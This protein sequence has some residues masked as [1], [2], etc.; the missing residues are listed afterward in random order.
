MKI[1]NYKFLII[2]GLAAY[3]LMGCKPAGGN[4]PGSEY[5]PDM[6]HS[7]AFEANVFEHYNLNTWSS[8]EELYQNAQPRKPVAGT[9]PFGEFGALNRG[10]FSPEMAEAMKTIP[11]NGYVPF[12]YPDTEEGRQAA[13]SEITKNPFPITE[14][15]LNNGKAL[16]NIYCGICHG[17]NGDGLGYLARDDGSYPVA[18]A[19]L[20]ADRFIDTT[21]GLYIYSIVHGKNVMGSYAD[22]LST[23][24]RWDVIHHIRKLQADKVGAEYSPESNTFVPHEAIT[25]KEA[26]SMM[27]NAGINRS[28]EESG[29]E[30][31][32]QDMNN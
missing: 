25:A 15:G 11:V 28:M 4:H 12:Y 26:Q 9:I 23:K 32:N 7:I 20:L 16:Y 6:F 10:S 1:L 13:A 31:Q 27:A 30:G 18:P 19:D 29:T 14:E 3:V 24:E 22:K 2:A 17:A 5:M 8:P 21:A